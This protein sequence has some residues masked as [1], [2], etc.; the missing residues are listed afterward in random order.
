MSDRV[1]GDPTPQPAEPAKPADPTEPN[2]ARGERL[3]PATR[4]L[5]ITR[6]ARSIGQGV[7]VV[8]FALYLN[9]LGWSAAAIGAVLSASS[10][11]GAALSLMIGPISDRWGRKPFLLVY[12]GLVAISGL[13][14]VFTAHPWLLAAAAVVG[15]FGR[16]ANGAAGPFGPAEQAWLAEAITPKQRGTIYSLN[17]AI[18]FFGMGLGAVF[19][20]LVPL[21]QGALPG[22]TA[23]RPLF[24]WVLAANAFNFFLLRR[25]P[26]GERPAAPPPSP[27]PAQA[28]MPAA[29]ASSAPAMSAP[30]I[31]P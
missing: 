8:D 30:P 23:Y 26:G 18:G 17:N 28:A 1:A 31:G 25:T 2:A 5:L 19:T 7:L 14:A 29:P 15:C 22:A 20:G 12:E 3:A 6:A 4:R 16:G 27:S 24:A 21:W 9:A 11:F 13:V 10:L